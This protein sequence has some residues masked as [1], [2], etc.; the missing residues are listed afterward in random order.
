MLTKCAVMG[1]KKET[2]GNMFSCMEKQ[3]CEYP[4]QRTLLIPKMVKS[5]S[6][7]LYRVECVRIN[8][9][10]THLGGIRKKLS[11]KTWA[12]KEVE[13]KV[14]DHRHREWKLRS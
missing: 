5:F 3:I 10:D 6:V 4:K 13:S 7:C 9:P 1:T 14:W 11:H 12:N 8:I 2:Q